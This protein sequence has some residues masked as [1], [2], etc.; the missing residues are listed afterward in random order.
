MRRKIIAGILLMVI[1]CSVF[2]MNVKAEEV[3]EDPEVTLVDPVIRDY[4][5]GSYDTDGSG[6][7]TE[8]ELKSVGYLSFYENN[9]STLED[10]PKFSDLRSLSVT[11]NES[12]V[13]LSPLKDNKT[14]V[15]LSIRGTKVTNFDVV[16][17]MTNLSQLYFSDCGITSVPDL[18]K[19]QISSIYNLQ[20][21]R[22][23]I[24]DYSFLK[25]IGNG[26]SV[27]ISD[28]TV[29]SI[30]FVK[31]MPNLKYFYLYNVTINDISPI[32]E[33]KNLESFG[34]RNCSGISTKDITFENYEKLGSITLDNV[35]V[36]NV[37]I[38][39][40][41]IVAI[42]YVNNNTNIKSV[43][44]N[45]SI[46]GTYMYLDH[47][48]LKDI[49]TLKNCENINYLQLD[50]TEVSDISALINCG[51]QVYLRDTNV[52]PYDEATFH[53]LCTIKEDNGG[54]YY[55][56]DVSKFLNTNYTTEET[57][58]MVN[59]SGNTITAMPVESNTSIESLITPE[60]F[61][62]LTSYEVKVYDQNG[63]VKT[64]GNIGS[65]NV[66][67]VEDKDGNVL[68]EYTVLVKGDVSGN[69]LT[70]IFDAFAILKGS[71]TPEEL[72]NIEKYIMDFNNDD[73]VQLYDAFKYL[74]KAIN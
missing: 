25:T 60:S 71:L 70:R 68:A 26:E 20:F 45:S 34:L 41:P 18:S 13:D 58:E 5:M 61:P 64:D 52:N 4:I 29:D 62:A 39:N 40:C 49:S 38:T 54:Y 33:C 21:D 44:I 32:F 12:V 9:I 28:A 35:G 46:K 11:D 3:V 31:D 63:N 6:T 22:N 69:G 74:Q 16:G 24:T 43:N 73:K 37:N 30:E 59:G 55:L 23:P 1:L 56:G 19:T 8:S 65:R 67:K 2:V 66:I 53:I 51:G 36:E 27:S 48:P 50:G 10:I 14:I 7:I 72:D 47:Q 17:T 42:L 15:D 57:E